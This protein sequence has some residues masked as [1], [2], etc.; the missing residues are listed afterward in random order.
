[1]ALRQGPNYLARQLKKDAR[2]NN[3]IYLEENLLRGG[4]CSGEHCRLK[5]NGIDPCR[6]HI[7][8]LSMF[9]IWNAYEIHPG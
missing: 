4:K 6:Y 5:E 2:C 9:S 3:G 8:P 1:M 7:H